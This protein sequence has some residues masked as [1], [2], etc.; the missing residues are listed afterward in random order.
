MQDYYRTMIDTLS[1][2]RLQELLVDQEPD[3]R[4]TTILV[5][6]REAV[7]PTMGASQTANFFTSVGCEL[8]KDKPSMLRHHHPLGKLFYTLT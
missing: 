8:R 4:K 1:L 3:G 6:F 5:F 2:S 7:R